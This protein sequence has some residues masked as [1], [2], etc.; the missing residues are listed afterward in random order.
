MSF[1]RV[2]LLAALIA[3]ATMYFNWIALPCLGAV[4]AVLRR[5]RHASGEAALAAM[6]GWGGLIAR[7]ATHPAFSTLLARLGE[8]FK[9]PG[10]AVAVVTLV[11]GV[12]LAWSASR[13]VSGFVARESH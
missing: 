10:V 6:L 13:L 11:F 2:L 3:V 1:L 8:L 7:S 4:Y 5:D 9:L 12:A